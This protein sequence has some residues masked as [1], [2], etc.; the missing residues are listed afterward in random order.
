M[1][2][3]HTGARR[4]KFFA[5]GLCEPVQQ[6]N[7]L[8]PLLRAQIEI[9][10]EERRA[11]GSPICIQ[12]ISNADFVTPPKIWSAYIGDPDLKE[13]LALA[14]RAERAGKPFLVWHTGDLT[15]VLPSE[16][17]MVLM[18][19]VDRSKRKR[20]WYVAPRFID[21]PL[22]AY[23]ALWEDRLTLKGFLA[24]PPRIFCGR[25]RQ[26]GSDSSSCQTGRG[27]TPIRCFSILPYVTSSSVGQ[28][29][30]CYHP[31]R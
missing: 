14:N 6:F 16:N 25:L 24:H 19:A 20:N 30:K 15:P 22:T 28:S 4:L 27:L 23:R 9:S 18:N 26:A 13:P 17:W 29:L 10:A 21:D 3:A 31:N 8:T 2:H 5:D 7:K 11:A 12:D 1:V